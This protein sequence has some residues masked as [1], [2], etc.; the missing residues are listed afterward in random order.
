MALK[1]K[2]GKPRGARR[3][4]MCCIVRPAVVCRLLRTSCEAAGGVR[5]AARFAFLSPS[6]L[7]DLATGKR[8][9]LSTGTYSAL[10]VLVRVA[11]AELAR[12]TIR[13]TREIDSFSRRCL[14]EFSSAIQLPKASPF[15]RP[16]GKGLDWNEAERRARAGALPYLRDEIGDANVAFIERGRRFTKPSELVQRWPQNVPVLVAPKTMRALRTSQEFFLQFGFSHSVPNALT[17]APGRAGAPIAVELD[18][19]AYVVLVS[20][21]CVRPPAYQPRRFP[22]DSGHPPRD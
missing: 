22:A 6:T 14:D 9:E 5:H 10:C 1:A 11:H 16:G 18:G 13:R 17:G 12:T 21:L 20:Q 3:R 19:K 4:D 7:H 2:R 8:R 15:G